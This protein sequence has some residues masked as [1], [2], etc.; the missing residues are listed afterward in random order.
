MKTIPGGKNMGKVK[1]EDIVIEMTEP[2][3]EVLGLELVDVEFLKE[4][5]SWF[6]R[7]FIDKPGGITHDDCQA[8]SERVGVILDEKDPIPQSYIMEVSSPGIERPLKKPT[9][10]EKFRGHK[11]RVS[12]FS[13][14]NGQKEFVGE[15]VG[16]EVG[17]VIIKVKNQDV[18]L[19]LGQVA[20]VRLEADF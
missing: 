15:L 7:L 9:D 1:I 3:V 5:G 12:T 14:V 19:S 20:R 4:G 16:L 18:T 13:P 11:V 2:I 17:N 6:L 10:F 8:V